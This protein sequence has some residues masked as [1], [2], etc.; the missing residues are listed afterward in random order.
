MKSLM[1]TDDAALSQLTQ[2]TANFHPSVQLLQ[3]SSKI[4]AAG[5]AKGGDFWFADAVLLPEST[6]IVITSRAHAVYSEDGV[7]KL[8]SY[9]QASPVFT[10]IKS[11]TRNYGDGKDVRYGVSFLVYIPGLA[12]FGIFHPNIPSARPIG[13]EILTFIRKPD[14]RAAGLNLPYTMFFQLSSF[15]REGKKPHFVPKITPIEMNKDEMPSEDQIEEAF[16]I[17]KAPVE[18]EA[19]VEEAT[20]DDR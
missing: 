6:I 19:K 9:D 4:V 12:K 14:E 5:K 10:K 16:K 15:L 8:E 20:G 11:I 17:F 18:S 7:K 1:K 2:G 13:A 3:P